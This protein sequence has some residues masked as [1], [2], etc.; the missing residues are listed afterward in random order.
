MKAMKVITITLNPAYDIHCVAP[1][2]ALHKETFAEIESKGIGGKGVNI[3]RALKANGRESTAVVVVGSG[4]AADFCRAL[5]AEGIDYIDVWTEGL[6]RQN[7]TF[8]MD[9]A[10]ETRISFNG[11]ACD[12]KVLAKIQYRIGEV[13]ENTIITVSG[14]IPKGI[15]IERMKEWLLEWKAKGVKLAVDSRSFTF[16]DL[17]ELQ[18]WLIK[19]N[20][21]EAK[22][23]FGEAFNGA[24]DAVACARRACAQGI[25][26]VII[27]LGG[28][29][30]VYAN[31]NETYKA[32]VP[33]IQPLSSIGA[34]DSLIA[35]FIAGYTS[36]ESVKQTFRRAVA[37][38]V[39][40]CLEKGTLPPKS[41]R[42]NAL[43]SEITI[44]DIL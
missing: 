28:D 21:A 31:R 12:E 4:N 25:E 40:A 5:E 6:I 13:D 43:L 29:G 32:S 17:V 41:E 8:Y 30:A 10:E 1:N 27:S 16:A 18:P 7:L 38:G 19:P 39:A 44:T 26:N 15:R 3:S 20:Q 37:Y 24:D 33:T 11:F 9:G 36:D 14:A 35:G 34:G 23:Y 22:N 42:V 2:L